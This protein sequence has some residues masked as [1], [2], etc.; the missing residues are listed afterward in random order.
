[1][2][3]GR[4]KTRNGTERNGTEAEVI[5]GRVRKCLYACALCVWRHACTARAYSKME[6]VIEV[7]SDDEVIVVSDN[8]SG[9]VS[10]GSTPVSPLKKKV[11]REGDGHALGE[12]QREQW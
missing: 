12:Y 7:L 3:R 4:Y 11:K 8:E 2:Q 10:A 6:D 5:I 9:S 1:V